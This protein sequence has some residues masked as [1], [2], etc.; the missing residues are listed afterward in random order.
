MLVPGEDYTVSFTTDYAGALNVAI[1]RGDGTERA[2]STGSGKAR[3]GLFS[4]K[5][6]MNGEIP[7]FNA[8]VVY[9]N[10]G[11]G[12][13]DE[14]V[15]VG[16]V[17]LERGAQA[18]DWC[19]APEDVEYVLS[20][21]ADS[22]TIAGSPTVL[23]QSDA[24][25]QGARRLVDDTSIE[26][27]GGWNTVPTSI[28]VNAALAKKQD[29]AVYTFR[30]G[31]TD[32]LLNDSEF[33]TQV[34]TVIK[35]GGDGIVG[36]LSVHGHAQSGEYLSVQDGILRLD[37]DRMFDDNAI[38]ADVFTGVASELCKNWNTVLN[39]NVKSC[40]VHLAVT[41]TKTD[42]TLS[43]PCVS[44]RLEYGNQVDVDVTSFANMEQ[45]LINADFQ[46]TTTVYITG[47]MP[48]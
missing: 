31:N 22:L 48:V 30:W 24:G 46:Y 16:H 27:E 3:N 6:K 37:F 35:A 8:Q 26:K 12:F 40:P 19:P 29:K 15:S 33:V 4:A 41:Y 1:M 20:N 43:E 25:V 39:I 9:I 28:G 32:S 34:F 13:S 14:S 47:V 21:K 10:Y 5:V 2:S 36:Q 38:E 18:T 42:G 17:K 7:P 11:G 44:G 23:G 45:G